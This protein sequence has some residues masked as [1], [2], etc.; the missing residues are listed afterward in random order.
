MIFDYMKENESSFES[1]RRKVGGFI[2]STYPYPEAVTLI[3][4]EEGNLEGLPH[5]RVL[6]DEDGDIYDYVA[7]TFRIVGIGEE[8]FTSL[9]EQ[10]I[11]KFSE[12][13]KISERFMST[14]YLTDQQ[15][16]K[17]LSSLTPLADITRVMDRREPG[18][19]ASIRERI[20][21]SV[22]YDIVSIK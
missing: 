19:T 3:C 4:N 5:N 15:M 16:E 11:K 13:F 6:R 17:L 7:G 21:N 18:H 20:R 12:L 1:R 9:G 2:Q 8:E 10:D 22:I 14:A